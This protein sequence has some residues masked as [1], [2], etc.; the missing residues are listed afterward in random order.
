MAAAKVYALNQ[1]LNISKQGLISYQD[2]K[3][4]VGSELQYEAQLSKYGRSE[5]RYR[6]LQLQ[7]QKE[8]SGRVTMITPKGAPVLIE[9]K[10][11]YGGAVE[12]YE[13]GKLVSIKKGTEVTELTQPFTMPLS[14]MTPTQRKLLKPEVLKEL[15]RQEQPPVSPDIWY[16]EIQKA[17][18]TLGPSLLWRAE[19]YAKDIPGKIRA[20]GEKYYP[21]EFEEEVSL[22]FQER[23][24]QYYGDKE[25]YTPTTT[26]KVDRGEIP[27]LFGTTVSVIADLTPIPIPR[28]LLNE[29]EVY[30]EEKGKWTTYG[31]KYGNRKV[32][33]Y[34]EFVENTVKSTDKIFEEKENK[35]I[36]AALNVVQAKYGIDFQNLVYNQNK[37]KYDKKEITWEEAVKK[38]EKTSEWK[39]LEKKFNKSFEEKVKEYEKEYE[40]PYETIWG[41]GLRAANI[42]TTKISRNNSRNI[43]WCKFSRWAWLWKSSNTICLFKANNNSNWKSI[44]I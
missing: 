5:E 23:G 18:V 14:E 31:K 20:V 24:T 21:S 37:D 8:K 25:F 17:P 27:G 42:S 6:E 34:K 43:G 12:V 9:G 13:N 41:G 44:R 2:V 10:M 40:V 16:G 4:Y 36:N 11:Y 1:A 22:P 33:F 30:D 32:I 19:E 39:E 35:I 3:S 15:T 26:I 29:Y 7:S 38:T 28:I